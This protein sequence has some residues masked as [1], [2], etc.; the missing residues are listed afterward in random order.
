MAGLN[1]DFFL[2]NRAEHPFAAYGDFAGSSGTVQIHDDLIHYM[3]DSLR[4]IPSLNP[5]RKRR[6]SGLNIHG[7]TII[8]DAGAPI[9]RR[10]LQSWER[11]FSS[12]PP[13]LHLTGGWCQTLGSPGTG[14]YRKLRVRRD[15]VISRLRGL[16]SL[17]RRVER[18][19]GERYLL[20]IGI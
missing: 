17:C 4:W 5:A 10:V 13:M 19:G 11:L 6:G 7:P 18:G 9:A 15:D 12:S 20:H 8:T 14:H 1:H 3:F 2:L 16:V